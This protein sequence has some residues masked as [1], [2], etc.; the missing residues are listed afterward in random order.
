VLDEKTKKH[1]IQNTIRRNIITIVRNKNIRTI[2][3]H[4]RRIIRTFRKPKITMTSPI[5]A[6]RF[7]NEANSSIS[8]GSSVM[9]DADSRR[10]RFFMRLRKS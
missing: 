8:G 4:K 2:R 9:R 1:N 5:F 6:T 3:K 7:L 10:R